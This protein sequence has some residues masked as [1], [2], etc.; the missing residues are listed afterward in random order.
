MSERQ[1]MMDQLV[2]KATKETRERPGTPGSTDLLDR[3]EALVLREL[4]GS[5]ETPE[6]PERKVIREMW[7]PLDLQVKLGRLEIQ[8]RRVPMGQ[9][10]LRVTLELVRLVKQDLLE[11][12]VM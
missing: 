1:E 9:Q 3:L 5:Q 4:K 2:L 7:G 11:R 6:S 8:A 12:Q 10:D